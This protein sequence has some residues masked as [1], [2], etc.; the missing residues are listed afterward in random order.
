MP[1]FPGI[2]G[3]EKALLSGSE[4]EV[5]IDEVVLLQTA[6]SFTDLARANRSYPVDRLELTL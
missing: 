1:L 5:A 6:K 2:F 3:G 4:L